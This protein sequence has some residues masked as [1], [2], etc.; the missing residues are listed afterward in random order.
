MRARFCNHSGIRGANLSRNAFTIVTIVTG[1]M[2][3]VARSLSCTPMMTSLLA[4]DVLAPI[5][6]GVVLAGAFSFVSG[7]FLA[8]RSPEFTE[9]VNEGPMR[10]ELEAEIQRLSRQ[11]ISDDLEDQLLGD[12]IAEDD[13]SLALS[14]FLRRIVPQPS[15]AFAAI[16]SVGSDSTWPTKARGLSEQTVQRLFI[17]EALIERLKSETT[18]IVR[19]DDDTAGLYKQLDAVD[20]PKALQLSL[21]ALHDSDEIYAV[22]MTSAGWPQGLTNVECHA[23]VKRFARFVGMR[24]RQSRIVEKQSLE[25]RVMQDVLEMRSIIDAQTDEP[26]DALSRFASR[27]CDTTSADR[28]AIY[29]VARRNGERLQPIVQCGRPLPPNTESIWQRH[30]RLLTNLAIDSE[31]RMVY[32]ADMLRA[33][34]TDSMFTSAA[35]MPI[36]VNGRVLGALCLTRQRSDG[37]LEK[38]RKLIECCADTLSQT[39]R[40]VFDESSIRRQ[41]RHD[42]LTD[43]VNRR[44]FDA[45]LA[46]ELERIRQGESPA[47]SLILADLDRFKSFNDR[48]GHQ[49]GDQ[50][51]RVASRVLAEQ[52]SHLR[53]GEHSIVARYG[54]EEFAILLPNVGMT[55]ALR[56]AEGIR[57]AIESET[58]RIQ[59]T[60]LKLTISLGVAVSPQQANSAE[61]LIAAAD[62]ALYQAKSNGRNCVC[63]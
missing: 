27:L 41:A 29:F 12:F 38:N 31:Q 16:V 9:T 21:T 54:G 56:I 47:C 10:S 55:V 3:F 42:H 26:L 45:Y 58:I 50:V 22:L 6:G 43:L 59:E 49:A 32:G 2:P 52:V 25:L 30:E 39:L 62:K 5:T 44:S 20:R 4:F 14:A 35:T 61:A 11:R 48:F 13:F 57:A 37:A 8:R 51:L 7:M 28:A 1:V 40:R 15:L 63:H 34:N 24:W 53:M 36:R 60:R 46:T 18:L 19:A 33:L 17:P 23:F